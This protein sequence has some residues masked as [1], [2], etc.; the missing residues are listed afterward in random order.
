MS[1]FERA[2]QWRSELKAGDEAVVRSGHYSEGQIVKVA[3]V[4][5][6]QVIIN[7]NL[8]FRKDNGRKVGESDVWHRTYLEELT[9]EVRG[10]IRHASL[11]SALG[12][13]KW[14]ALSLEVLEA[15]VAAIPTKK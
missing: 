13:I 10:R 12:R 6:T 14:E 9:D 7:D 1:Q 2:K 4:T 5:A 8:R 3:R 15:V 11:A